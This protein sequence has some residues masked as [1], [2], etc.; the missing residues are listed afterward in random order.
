MA[1]FIDKIERMAINH[2]DSASP[3][4]AKMLEIASAH[5]FQIGSRDG[6]FIGPSSFCDVLQ[7]LLWAAMKEDEQIWLGQSMVNDAKELREKLKLILAQIVP[8]EDERLGEDI[9]RND[10]GVEKVSLQ[11]HLTFLMVPF[12]QEREF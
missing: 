2:K 5:R 4:G 9:V 7:G 1:G 3:K 6:L 10:F 11:A 12:S 8:C